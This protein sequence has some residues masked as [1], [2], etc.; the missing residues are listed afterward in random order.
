MIYFGRKEP[1]LTSIKLFSLVLAVAVIAS[2]SEAQKLKHGSSG[3][4]QITTSTFDSLSMDVTGGFASRISSVSLTLSG[5]SL[6]LLESSSAMMG[7]VEKRDKNVTLNAKEQAEFIRML[8]VARFPALSE[9]YI[10]KGL[11]D[12]GNQQ[13][14]LKMHDMDGKAHTYSVFN[15]G[16]SAPKGFQDLLHAYWKLYEQKFPKP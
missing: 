13:L 1:F 8:N 16:K 15:Y 11:M 5:R 6:H 10:Q 9:K 14:T 3:T 7:K 2:A 12:A 4:K